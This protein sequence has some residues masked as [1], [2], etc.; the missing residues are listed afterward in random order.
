VGPLIQLEVT[1]RTKESERLLRKLSMP[2]TAIH[3]QI[4]R[5]GAPLHLLPHPIMGKLL[6]NRD[7]HRRATDLLATLGDVEWKE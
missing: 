6:A 2:Y 3:Q 4:N 1:S 5:L 7:F